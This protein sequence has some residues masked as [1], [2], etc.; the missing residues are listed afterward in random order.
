MIFGD[1]LLTPR[2]SLRRVYE[3][4]LQLLVDWSNNQEAHG[5]YLTP[6]GLDREMALSQIA[7]GRLW[8]DENRVFLVEL[9][10]GL[11]IGTVHYWLRSEYKNCG[12][13]AL[14]IA[15]PKNRNSGYGTEAQKYVIINLF[16]RQK[17][18]A[19]EMYTDIN[20]LAQQRCL[21]KLGFELVET[22]SYED[23]QVNRVGH[24]FR[25]DVTMYSKSL[26]YQYHYEE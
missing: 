5:D 3:E 22:L 7:T 9:K 19:V 2:L 25:L 11:P 17:V 1:K 16:E 6:E 4:D 26:Y 13:M 18:E 21:K 23:H 24:L 8:N 15:D 12:V 10:N 20:N 14:K